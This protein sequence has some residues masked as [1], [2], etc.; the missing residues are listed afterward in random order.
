MTNLFAIKNHAIKTGT[1]IIK[2][3]II[4]IIFLPLRKVY[5]PFLQHAVKKNKVIVFLPCQEVVQFYFDLF[6]ATLNRSISSSQSDSESESED[7]S[8]DDVPVYALHGSMKQQVIFLIFL[9]HLFSFN[10]FNALKIH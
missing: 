10:Q 6:N 9:F 3:K 2:R 5:L 7:S 4:D 8:G 1:L